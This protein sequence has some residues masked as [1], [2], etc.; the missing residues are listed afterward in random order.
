M[1]CKYCGKEF[2]KYGIKNH[3]IHCK[4][5]PNYIPGK[6]NFWIHPETK[7]KSNQ[8]IKAKEL[9]LDKPIISNET[10]NKIGNSWRNKKHSDIE[11][12]KIKE[13]IKE[14]INTGNW[15][16]SFSKSRIIE[17]K[18]I[19][20]LGSWEA[21]FARYLDEHNIKWERPNKY[22]DYIFENENHKYL[23][24][25]YLPDYNLYIEI[26][27]YPTN[28]DFAKWEQFNNNL[29]I[30]FGDDLYKLGIIESYK[31]VYNNVNK[32]RYKHLLLGV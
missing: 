16:L 28:K 4:L 3:E 20:F 27:G 29:D 5:N 24:D 25:F 12:Q 1:Y 23:P 32:F 15:H 10:K 31:N 7:I 22:F 6:S 2:N 13:T 18:G 21:N 14:N 26:K 17:Y 8:F 19:K 11:K 9:G 30:Y